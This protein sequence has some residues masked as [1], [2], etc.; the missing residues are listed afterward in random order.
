MWRRLLCLTMLLALAGCASKTTPEEWKQYARGAYLQGV[1]DGKAAEKCKPVVVQNTIMIAPHV[2]PACEQAKVD[3]AS[4]T[5]VS[6]QADYELTN[7]KKERS[8]TLFRYLELG[9]KAA[10]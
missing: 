8:Q 3:A 10:K 2:A 6:R 9:G 7:N 1:A 4:I 5:E